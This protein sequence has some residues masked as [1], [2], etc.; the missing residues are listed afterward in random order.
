M[1]LPGY[2]KINFTDPRKDGFIIEP[3]QTDGGIAPTSSILHERSRRSST[4]LLLYGRDVPNYGERIAENFVHLLENFAGPT[5]PKSPIEGQLWFDTGS[6]F[7]I[8][9]K[10]DDSSVTLEGDHQAQFAKLIADRKVLCLTYRPENS[11]IDNSLQTKNVLCT[12]VSVQGGNTIVTL[13][14]ENEESVKLPTSVIGGY[15]TVYNAESDGRQYSRMRVATK[16]AGGIKWI[17]INNVYSS[18]DAPDVRHLSVGDLWLDTTA[19]EHQLKIVGVDG[20]W[21]SV[22]ARY[23]PLDGGEMTGDLNMGTHIVYSSHSITKNTE[24]EN[25]LIN[26][27]YVDVIEANVTKRFEDVEQDINEL[28]G[29]RLNAKVNKSGDVMTG[30]LVFGDAD[31]TTTLLR[32]ID[33]NKSPIKGLSVSFPSIQEDYLTAGQGPNDAVNKE[34]VARAL[35]Y[36]KDA[37]ATSTAGGFIVREANGTGTI[38]NSIFFNAGTAGTSYAIAWKDVSGNNN[39]SIYANFS[40][41]ASQ[42]IIEAGDDSNDSVDIRHKLQ[43]PTANPLFRFQSTA[44]RSFTSLY[45]HDG[46]PQPTNNDE[47]T[48][49]VDDNRAATKGFV[50]DY[51]Q[52]FVPTSDGGSG[53]GTT[54]TDIIYGHDVIDGIYQYNLTVFQS[55]G[56]EPITVNQYHRHDPYDSMLVHRI[57]REGMWE[58]ASDALTDYLIDASPT[59]PAV[60]VGMFLDGLTR[61]RAP[62]SGAV[63]SDLPR[64][65][66]EA[67]IVGYDGTKNAIVIE[68]D[69]VAYAIAGAQVSVLWTA[70]SLN[71]GV[72]TVVSAEAGAP[73]DNG[74]PTTLVVVEKTLGFIGTETSE[75]AAFRM[76]YHA[77]PYQADALITRGTLDMEIQKATETKYTYWKATEVG[78]NV[79][80]T[81]P[82]SYTPGSHKLWIFKNGQKQRVGIMSGGDFNE[83][84][85]TTITIASV[86][87]GDEFEIYEI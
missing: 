85:S 75:V 69:Y 6:Y 82:F 78:V 41:I 45:I 4:S 71:D 11:A 55:N 60:S 12:A 70:G 14:S 73:L 79:V 32:G 15:L 2:Y 77:Y 26:R 31:A 46:Q 53:S 83:T 68:G 21:R 7:S 43:S 59:Y 81:L 38:P 56:V 8:L 27:R 74:T 87:A 80:R 5:D 49:V 19:D 37:V 25:A 17:D 44:A 57:P 1:A 66:F 58:D 16:T 61:H 67:D 35:T 72:Y 30:A 42:L 63:F 86:A 9:N 3:Y 23:V 34:Y 20:Q 40:G 36:L 76:G 24:H 50:R 18:E 29:P 48:A 47:I 39:H 54:V 62:L 33:M 65:G 10:A 84:T 52:K 22:A 51:V 13:V 28:A 64:A